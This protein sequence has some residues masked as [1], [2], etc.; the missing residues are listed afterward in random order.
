MTTATQP[1]AGSAAPVSSPGPIILAASGEVCAATIETVRR[2]AVRD[3]RAVTVVSAVSLPPASDR[4]IGGPYVP[5]ADA[6]AAPRRSA[7]A[8]RLAAS[9]TDAA[10][11]PIEIALDEPAHAITDAAR[12][13]G[14]T[15]IALSTG[16]HD[17]IGRLAGEVALRVTRHTPCPVLVI[18]AEPLSA[19]LRAAVAA[20][21][22]SPSSVVAARA[23]AELLDDGAT[24]HLVHV[25]PTEDAAGERGLADRLARVERAL[26]SRARALTIL[27]SILV[28]DPAA[29][30]VAFAAT[31]DAD[32]V[33]LGHHAR[34]IVER[35]FVGSIAMRTLR[36]ATGA[37]LVTPEPRL[38]ER[39]L[40]SRIID[41]AFESRDRSEW[42]A[43]LDAFS[44]RNLTRRTRIE[45]HDRTSS[46]RLQEDGYRLT[47]V[48]YDPHDH[49]ITIMLGDR[50]GAPGHVTHAIQ[51]VRSVTM[52]SDEHLHD[53]ALELVHG[54]ATTVLTFL[55]DDR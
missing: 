7:L 28:G 4:L 52:R 2:L 8:R 25:R 1:T 19:P 39:D 54:A 50:T 17:V 33:A 30:I 6:Y 24:L 43:L 20:I 21:D 11:W 31:H 45:I 35:L 16:R 27:P 23:A 32:L 26:A 48:T 15:L 42:G 51:D 12:R 55:P 46:G 49:R 37:V 40:V 38:A 10:A 14:A 53:T 9:G 44:D 41:G 34:G 13:A 5:D 3:G 22:F 18:G 47:G 29:Q 36:D